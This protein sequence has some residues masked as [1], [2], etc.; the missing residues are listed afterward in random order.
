MQLQ[1][2]KRTWRAAGPGGVLL[3]LSCRVGYKLTR[4]LV[5]NAL[6][7]E[8][9]TLDRGFLDFPG[10]F[11]HGFLDPDDVRRHA[12]SEGL[13]LP[14]DFVEAALAKGDLCYGILDGER[15]VSYFWYAR[16]AT[17]V[18]DE[19]VLRFDPAY[20]YAYKGYTLPEYRGQRLY[21]HGCAHALAALAQGGSRGC[22]TLVDVNN[23]ASMK[24]MTR[25]GYVPV[26]RFRAAKVAGRWSIRSGGDCPRYGMSMDAGPLGDASSRV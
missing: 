22:V 17:L 10:R 14:A 26:G 13:E 11:R 6:V 21:A 23:F 1:D 9:G 15:L 2:L 25:T 18:T 3:D 7:L 20:R 8:P 16:T 19:L 4:L 12:G 5:M 24:S